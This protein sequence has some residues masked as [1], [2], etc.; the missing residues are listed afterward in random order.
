MMKA[1]AMIIIFPIV[2]LFF[3]DYKEF[4]FGFEPNF[5]ALKALSV[6][7]LPQINFNLGFWTYLIPGFFYAVAL[8][9]LV[10][11]LIYKKLLSD[12]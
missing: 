6:A 5:W 11:V 3:T 9:I 12:H 2:A 7:M 10:Y 1:G 4:L 8:N